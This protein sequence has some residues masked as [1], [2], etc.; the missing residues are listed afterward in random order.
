M[1]RTQIQIT[2]HQARM[3]KE[4]AQRRGVSMAELVRQAIDTLT[5]GDDEAERWRRATAV[6][7]RFH[8]GRSDI[9]ER[10]DDYLAEDFR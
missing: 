1:I 7:G 8:S 9:S 4:L 3:L 2:E 6:I 10:H 5:E